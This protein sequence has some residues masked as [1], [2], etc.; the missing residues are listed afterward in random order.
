MITCEPSTSTMSAS[1]SARH[2]HYGAPTTPPHDPRLGASCSASSIGAST[3]GLGAC[4]RKQPFATP[5]SNRHKRNPPTVE[6]RR[7]RYD[8]TTEGRPR[9][10][11]LVPLQPC[12]LATT[13]TPAH[14]RV[15]GHCLFQVPPIR[16]MRSGNGK[17]QMSACRPLR[18]GDPC[19]NGAQH[20]DNPVLHQL[21]DETRI[22][23]S[24]P[25]GD[26]AGAWNE[27]PESSCGVIQEGQDELH[28][29]T[30]RPPS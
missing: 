24:E 19:I 23:V 5:T 6:R 28:R 15:V 9:L 17:V 4:T 16:M 8:P 29:F 30:P 7:L 1:P 11:Q 20:P 27:L 22:V 14:S 13:H 25:L 21:S 26:L 18:V 2:R 3:G 12:A 10:L